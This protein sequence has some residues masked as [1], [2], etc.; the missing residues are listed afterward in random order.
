MRR[1]KSE[2]LKDY[3][4]SVVEGIFKRFEIDISN[5]KYK[6]FFSMDDMCFSFEI[7]QMYEAPDIPFEVLMDIAS[8]FSTKKIDTGAGDERPG[9]ETCDYGSNYGIKVKIMKIPESK[10]KE[11]LQS[12]GE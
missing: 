1:E 10:I 4:D 11:S 7:S 3:F 12:R 5:Y 2:I 9:C 6:S 8:A